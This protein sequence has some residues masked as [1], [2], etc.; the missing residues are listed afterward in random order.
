MENGLSESAVRLIK[1]NG[2]RILLEKIHRKFIFFINI[3]QKV[4]NEKLY[5]YNILKNKELPNQYGSGKKGSSMS[6]NSSA[7]KSRLDR[8][9]DAIER[10]GNKLPDPITM[11]LGLAIIVTI[12]SAICSAAGVSAVNPADGSTI[13]VFNLLSLDGIRYLWTN[14]IT[15]FSGFAPLGMVLVAVIG[16]S[17]A[18]KSGFLVAVM[19]NFLGKAKGWI[20]TMVIMFLGINLNIAGD[21]GF[22]VLPPLAAILYMSI[23][24]H[25][26]LGMYT[27]FASV[28]AGFCANILLGLSDALA[29]GFT[30]QAAQMIDPNYQ[31]SIA[32]N[33]YFLIVSCVLLT[34]VGTILVEKVLLHRF[35]VSKEELAKYDFDEDNSNITPIQKKG[36]AAAGLSVLIYAAV[37]VF[38]CLP[39]F[40]GRAI[41]ADENG[42][43]TSGASPFSK[44]IVF[45]VTLFLMIPG[46]VYGI[47]IGKYKSDKDVWADISQGFAEMGNYIF[48]CFFISIF[49]NFFSVSKLGT[50]LAIKGANLLSTIGFTGIPL[51]L[52]LIFLSCIVNI[53]IGSA[54]AKWAILAPVFIPMMMLM[55]FDPAITQVV[56]R[57][58]DSI[59]N[60]LS[61]LFTYLPVILGFAH[62]YDEKVGLGTVIAN[63]LPFSVT[64]AIAWILQ[65]VIWVL[66]NLPLGPGGAIYL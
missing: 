40:G 61:P 66:L 29:Y 22:I 2:S 43:I 50:V 63:M 34:I 60:P 14:V 3:Q 49:T 15:N 28:A 51:L 59:T 31:Q 20:V 1:K 53:F 21:A 17:V 23:G 4:A 42:S 13:E 5:R 62:K 16:S 54:S 47:V 57:I 48:M 30:E 33:W 10:A 8:I 56:Y 32:I 46:I 45:T 27:A 18:E 6:E 11:F 37:V 35:P 52:G 58:G 9:L 44:G 36:I 12:I 41:L 64:F 26:L 24:R 25:P 38:M 65:V 39:I 55:G 19:V 7:K